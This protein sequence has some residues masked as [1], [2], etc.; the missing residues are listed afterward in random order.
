MATTAIG[1]LRWSP[2]A[3]L[4][5]Q[6]ATIEGLAE[7]VGEAVRN[8]AT[9]PAVWNL[10]V[11]ATCRL[12]GSAMTTTPRPGDVASLVTEDSTPEEVMRREYVGVANAIGADDLAT[13]LRRDPLKAL[14][15]LHR[16]V[17]AGLVAPPVTGQLRRTQQAVH[18]GN[19]GRLVFQ[20]VDPAE[21]AVALPFLRDL[22]AD[23]DLHPVVT[24]GLLQFEVLR[25]HPFESANGRL[26]R[27]AARHVLRE[28][29]LDPGGLAAAEIPMSDRPVGN[30]DAVAAALRSG[31]LTVWLETWAEDVAAGLR[32][33]ADAMGIATETA[34]TDLLDALP[35]RFT[36][37]RLRDEMGDDTDLDTVR[38]ASARLADAGMVTIDSGTRG[39]RLR[40]GGPTMPGW[41]RRGIADGLD[42]PVDP[43]HPAEHEEGTP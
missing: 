7:R 16:T 2:S 13:L 34:P 33:A 18:D 9:A 37:A 43:R 21:I 29:G 32:L 1:H 23:R 3:H 11:I 17:T 40:R 22:V 8:G 5:V 39:L 20:P 27:V 31:N 14:P 42:Q 12:D 6:L 35:D 15:A 25:L 24:A 4:G 41:H 26:A 28:A 10:A 36:L 30:Y 19:E 38:R